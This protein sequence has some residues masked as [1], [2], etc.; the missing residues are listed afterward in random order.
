[1][2]KQQKSGLIA[3]CTHVFNFV[4]F[5][6]YFNHMHCMAHWSR[7]YEL[8]LIGK[9]GLEAA[10]ARNR[11]VD[12]VIEKE[13]SHALFI[14]GDHFMPLET[15][16]FLLETMQETEGAMV[17]GVVCKKGERFQQVNW[18][19]KDEDGERRYYEM[20]LPLDGRLYEVSICAFGCTLVDIKKLKKLKKPYFRDTC[21]EKFKGE[22]VNIR[23]DIN[24]CNMFRDNGERIWVDTRILIGHQ[25][26]PSIVYPQSG[27][28][29]GKLREIEGELSRLKDGQ[30]GKYY[31]PGRDV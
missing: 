30:V 7:D 3:I 29:F 17:S 9:S 2:A 10:T 4:D 1:M 11:I 24:I 14:D 20:S 13:C 12:R 18:Q 5:D 15:L 28:L 26:V 22:P 25:G 16:P 21:D 6:I 31:C 19:V 23:S 8:V 27:E